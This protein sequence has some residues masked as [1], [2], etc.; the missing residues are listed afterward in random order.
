MIFSIIIILIFLVVTYFQYIQGGFTAIISAGCAL[1]AMLLAFGY[2]EAVTGLLA[3]GGMADFAPGAILIAL[4]GVSYII[5]RVVADSVVPGNIALQLY[6]D[7]VCA[8]LFGAGAAA[9]AVGV[10]A[11][12]AQ[13]M[14][15]GPTV[16]DYARFK[17]ATRTGVTI[18]KDAMSSS[19]Q[20]VD[21]DVRDELVD[22]KLDP[23]A[24]GEK[25]LL[26][27][28]DWVVGIARF[29][30]DGSLAGGQSFSRVHPDLLGQATVNRSGASLGT[31]RLA[32]NA[33]GVESA[34]VTGVFTVAGAKAYDAELS[35]F[36]E[37][38]KPFDPK[39]PNGDLLAVR[40]QF[41]RVAADSDGKVRLPLGAVRLNVDGV[42][43]RAVGTMEAG[44]YVG[45]GRPDDLVLV[46][47]KGDNKGADF[48]FAVPAPVLAQAAPGK[49]FKA[50]TAFVEVKMFARTDLAGQTIGDWKASPAAVVSRK[51]LAPI[52]AVANF[53]AAK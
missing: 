48:V 30:S 12:G 29:A 14:P 8:A 40:V 26:P 36:R 38:N 28:D 19:R 3:P 21:T 13:L 22:P 45:V 24:S 31:A 7:R 5:L 49:K 4:F 27:V 51:K 41:E 23:V 2:Y 10:F 44:N 43:Y 15:F 20:D 52:G 39:L 50:D 25:L 47:L 35:G 42:D 18:P 37:G 34:K 17:V 16:G 6:V 53:P 32:I 1:L 33:G 46:E 11:V 9:M